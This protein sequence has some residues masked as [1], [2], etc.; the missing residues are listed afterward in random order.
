[1]RE[2]ILDTE[3]TGLNPEQ[4]DRIVEVGCVELFGR[5]PTGRVF[6]KYLNPDRKMSAEALNITGLSD[7]FLTDKQRFSDIAKEFVSFIGDAPLVIHNAAFDIK[8]LNAELNRAGLA[9]LRP[10]CAI[11]TLDLARRRFPGSPLNLD[12]L[13]RRFG[14]NNSGREKHGALLDSELLAEVYLELLGGRQS[15]LSFE[16]AET[17]AAFV[18]KVRVTI[19]QRK[20]P[21]PERISEAERAAHLAFVQKLGEKA[22]WN[23]YSS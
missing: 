10:G 19:F 3:T 18:S 4:G 20:T 7:E 22:V 9:E 2:V 11:D 15:V 12:A 5:I 6:H 8:F 13:C 17:A 23:S 16:P 14:I 1:M 21:L